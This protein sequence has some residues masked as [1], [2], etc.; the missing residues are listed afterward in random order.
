M[1][2]LTDKIYCLVLNNGIEIWLNQKQ[3]DWVSDRLVSLESSKFI[4]IEG[5]IIN[6]SA[7]TG[8]ISGEKMKTKE[9]KK[10]GD[11]QCS[12]GFWHTRGQECAHNF[13]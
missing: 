13:A 9:R 3:K 11:Y 8:I 5:E 1:K 12:Y 7:I 4:E 10:M 2:Q 6:S